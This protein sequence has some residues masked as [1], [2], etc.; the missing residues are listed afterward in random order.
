MNPPARRRHAL[1]VAAGVGL[2]LVAGVAF[3]EVIG[4]PFLAG[5]VQGALSRTLQREVLLNRQGADSHATV[6][7]LGGLKVK[8]PEL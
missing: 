7:F 4:W 1:W 6:R 5:P 8:V 3:C 2:L